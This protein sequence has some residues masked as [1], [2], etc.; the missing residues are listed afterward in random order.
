MAINEHV[1]EFARFPLQSSVYASQTIVVSSAY[2]DVMQ[3]AVGAWI[4]YAGAIREVCALG[5]FLDDDGFVLD[6]FE[7]Q[8]GVGG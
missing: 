5:T 1:A 6:A 4:V 2:W 3:Q 7:I 8:I